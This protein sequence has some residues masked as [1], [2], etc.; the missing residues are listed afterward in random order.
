MTEWWHTGSVLFKS[1]AEVLSYCPVKIFPLEIP[2]GD[3]L[4]LPGYLYTPPRYTPRPRKIPVLIALNEA[5][6]I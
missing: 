5:D 3:D 1:S 4:K 6:S 2:F